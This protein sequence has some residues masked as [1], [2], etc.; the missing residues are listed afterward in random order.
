MNQQN[1]NR[2]AHKQVYMTQRHTIVIAI[3]SLY[4]G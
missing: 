1:I 2:V 3:V 4:R